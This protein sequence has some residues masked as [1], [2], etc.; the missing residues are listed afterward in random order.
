[1]PLSVQ[2]F[3][4]LPLNSTSVIC[5]VSFCVTWIEGIDTF[6]A[7]VS[8]CENRVWISERTEKLLALCTMDFLQVILIFYEFSEKCLGMLGW[9]SH[10]IK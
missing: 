8:A 4:L 5:V 10:I 2:E 3:L 6:H 9:A 7:T 1:M